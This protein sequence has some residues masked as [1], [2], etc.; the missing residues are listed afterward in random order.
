MRPTNL[1]AQE[2]SESTGN[3][4]W[5]NTPADYTQGRNHNPHLAYG[6]ESLGTSG[7]VPQPTKEAPGSGFHG[8]TTALTKPG[9]TMGDFGKTPLASIFKGLFGQA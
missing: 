4:Q 6:P 1:P 7:G 3:P 8:F 5:F 9:T 2:G